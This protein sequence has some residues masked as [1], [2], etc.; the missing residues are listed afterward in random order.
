[1]GFKKTRNVIREILPQRKNPSKKPNLI[2]FF[3][4]LFLS[5]LASTNVASDKRYKDKTHTI[6]KL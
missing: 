6:K 2:I 4:R 1:M 3:Y 5:L